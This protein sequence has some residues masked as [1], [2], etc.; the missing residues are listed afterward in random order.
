MS[1]VGEKRC[2]EGAL[3]YLLAEIVGETQD[4]L[5]CIGCYVQYFLRFLLCLPYFRKY[6][7]RLIEIRLVY[8]YYK[9]SVVRQGPGDH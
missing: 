3:V 2:V 6:V 8:G 7:G 4:S 9:R 1:G 5:L